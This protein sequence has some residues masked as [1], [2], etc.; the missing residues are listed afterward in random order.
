MNDSPM[1]VPSPIDLRKMDDA[2]EWAEKAMERR[3]WREEFFRTIAQELRRLDCRALT[4][5]ELGSGPG[6]LAQ[7]VLESSLTAAYVALDFSPSMHTLAKERLGALA[8][9]VQFLE[10]DFRNAGWNTG[11]PMFNAVVSVQAVHELRHK[12][13][14]PSFYQRVRPLLRSRG[15]FLM[16]DHFCGQGGMS[17]TSL[18]MTSEE[19]ERALRTGG[20]TRVEMLLEKG[21]LT[22]FR[23]AP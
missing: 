23:A 21:G 4:V 20:F 12:Q 6:F 3:P 17:D 18:Y 13:H 22:L 14:A 1:A 7:R 16:C 15:V 5:L 2:R 8:D 10:A 19:H 9:R 11:L